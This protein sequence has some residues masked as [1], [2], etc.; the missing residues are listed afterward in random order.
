MAIIQHPFN[1]LIN[2]L[3]LANGKPTF[4]HHNIIRTT[5][6]FNIE[7][8]V[9]GFN[10]NDIDMEI[11]DNILHIIGKIEDRD[12]SVD[13]VHHGIATR[14]FH[15]TIQLNNLLKVKGADLNHGI[16]SIELEKIIPDECKPKKIVIGKRTQKQELLVE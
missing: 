1:E 11:V 14:S 9:A 13:Y 3:S 15:K 2:S 5:E 8:A 4:P 7:L 6:G 12:P 10:E 16:L